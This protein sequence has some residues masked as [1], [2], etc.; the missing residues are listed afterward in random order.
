MQS[1]GKIKG[2]KARGINKYE[3]IKNHLESRKDRSAW[4]K[5]VTAYAYEL[6]DVVE[7]RAESQT[8]LENGG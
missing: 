8:I 3:E 2:H 1:E 4:N 6:L 7:E 5:G